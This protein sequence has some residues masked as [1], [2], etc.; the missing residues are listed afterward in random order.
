MPST[1]TVNYPGIYEAIDAAWTAD[2]ADGDGTN[3]AVQDAVATVID[4][5]GTDPIREILTGRSP[6]A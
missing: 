2:Q 1:L 3:F 6:R 4:Q 5:Y